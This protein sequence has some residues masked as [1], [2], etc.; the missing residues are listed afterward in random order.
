MNI[1]LR[2]NPE[3]STTGW[4]EGTHVFLHFLDYVNEIHVI[5]EIYE[6]CIIKYV[7]LLNDATLS[8]YSVI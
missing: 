8:V 5:N 6:V 1:L 7:I 4:S 3:N 2:C